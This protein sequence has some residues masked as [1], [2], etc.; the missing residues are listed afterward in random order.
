MY[1]LLRDCYYDIEQTCVIIIVMKCVI[2]KLA[3]YFGMTI[4]RICVYY[5]IVPTLFKY[6]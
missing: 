4:N 1:D 6:C 5:D 3:S 2:M